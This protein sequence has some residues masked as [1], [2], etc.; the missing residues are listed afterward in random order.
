MKPGDLKPFMMADEFE[1]I[2]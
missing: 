1:N 2:W